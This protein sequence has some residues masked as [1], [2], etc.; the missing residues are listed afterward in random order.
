MYRIIEIHELHFTLLLSLSLSLSLST[1]LLVS[2]LFLYRKEFNRH[3]LRRRYR[4][5]SLS[6]PRYHSH[7][8]VI[9]TAPCRR[10]R[11]LVP[12]PPV[13]A[14]PPPHASVAAT[15]VTSHRHPRP[16]TPHPATLRP[17]APAPC[18]PALACALLPALA[19]TLPTSLHPHTRCCPR[20]RASFPPHSRASCRSRV[21]AVCRPTLVS[22]SRSQPP[23]PAL[24]TSDLPCWSQTRPTFADHP[25]RVRMTSIITTDRARALQVAHTSPP[26]YF[27]APLFLS[28]FP[29]SIST[30][31]GT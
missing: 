22:G 27:K 29:A 3:R 23:A 21:Q 7:L 10:C 30:A 25:C 19:H 11:S 20:L 14:L 16:T 12:P 5:H 4:R 18:R 24:R 2:F 17:A 13:L 26:L 9:T 8:A 28:V 15:A 31:L 1:S 6:W